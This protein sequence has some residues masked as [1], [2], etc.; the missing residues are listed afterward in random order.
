MAKDPLP[1]PDQ[2]SAQLEKCKSVRNE[3]YHK[4]RD[5]TPEEIESSKAKLPPLAAT[6][7]PTKGK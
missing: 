1:V 2:L 7:P 6:T 4:S 3:F 5:K